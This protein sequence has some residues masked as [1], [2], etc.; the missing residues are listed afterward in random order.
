M[1]DLADV[2]GGARAAAAAE[3]ARAASSAAHRHVTR[4]QAACGNRA[5]QRLLASGDG[6]AVPVQ[7][8]GLAHVPYT[9]NERSWQ[10]VAMRAASPQG[11]KNIASIKVT[12]RDL[13]TASSIPP[14]PKGVTPKHSEQVAWEMVA[15]YVIGGAARIEWVYTE[16]EPCGKGPGMKNCAQFLDGLLRQYG[17][18]GDHTP[19]YYSF[20]YPSPQ[21]VRSVAE[22]YLRQG[23]VGNWDD[24]YDA[25]YDL[26]LQ[27][28][29]DTKRMI[30][31]AQQMFS[32]PGPWGAGTFKK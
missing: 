19:V 32:Q 9:G 24:A 29:G 7:R 31:E 1:A 26:W 14:G 23:V 18:A 30:A 10:A 15:P 13:A 27:E 22:E 28:H 8:Y 3:R 25:A 2:D 11:L 21:E 12:G 5:V 4:L 6:W 16:R 17:V 20:N